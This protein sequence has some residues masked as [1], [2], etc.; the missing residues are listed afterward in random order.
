M[1]LVARQEAVLRWMNVCVTLRRTTSVGLAAAAARQ[2]HQRTLDTVTVTAVT[3]MVIVVMDIVTV[4]VTG[5]AVAISRIQH[6][7]G[8]YHRCIIRQTSAVSAH[9]IIKL[10]RATA[11]AQVAL[12]R[13]PQVIHVIS[14][15]I[16]MSCNHRILSNPSWPKN[17]CLTMIFSVSRRINGTSQRRQTLQQAQRQQREV[18]DTVDS[19]AVATHRQHCPIW[20]PRRQPPLLA[21]AV[22]AMPRVVP[23]AVARQL[24][25]CC[26]V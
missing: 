10:D 19:V 2:Q 9:R 11:T 5:A 7:P 16:L 24:E 23:A 15:L 14:S 8:S 17:P 6:P 13:V 21:T 4:T 18:C 26:N 20:R 12:C 25:L 3:A 22:Q 1:C